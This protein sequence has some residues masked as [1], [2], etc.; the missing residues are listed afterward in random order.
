MFFSVSSGTQVTTK[1]PTSSEKGSFASFRFNTESQ[2]KVSNGLVL[3]TSRRLGP[4]TKCC[5][6]TV[7]K[8]FDDSGN[9]FLKTPPTSDI[10]T[11]A[12]S[13]GVEVSNSNIPCFSMTL[14]QNLG[15]PISHEDVWR[16]P[17][18]NSTYS[19]TPCKDLDSLQ[20]IQPTFWNWGHTE[21]RSSRFLPLV[22]LCL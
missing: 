7:T 6:V 20:V 16:Q 17:Y 18:K 8:T 4:Q 2:I 1:F 22:S 12:S 13:Q 3:S 15:R 5:V 14:V 9:C 21:H 11:S 10:S 19:A